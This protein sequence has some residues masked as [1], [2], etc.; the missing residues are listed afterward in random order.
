M[1]DGES[2]KELRTVGVS[3]ICCIKNNKVSYMQSIIMLYELVLRNYI[4]RVQVASKEG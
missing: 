4:Y 3:S 1:D 2:I